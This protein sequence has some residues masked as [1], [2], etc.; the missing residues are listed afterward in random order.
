MLTFKKV[1]IIG[2]GTLGTQIAAQ[3]ARHGVNTTLFDISTAS[4]NAAKLEILNADAASRVNFRD[5]FQSLD[6]DFELVIESITE[7]LKMKQKLFVDIELKFP[8][9]FYATN[10]S[11]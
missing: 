8:K 1:L 11:T 3:F 4:L 9:A 2:A 7:N 5:D 10:S 6:T